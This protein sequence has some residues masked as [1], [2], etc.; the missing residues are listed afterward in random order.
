[1]EA[2]NFGTKTA[3]DRI[4]LDIAGQQRR[5]EARCRREGR[6]IVAKVIEFYIPNNPRK[7]MKWVPRELRGKIIEFASPIEKSAIEKS[8]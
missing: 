6:L 8:A 4:A 5:S 7:S 3:L 1:V 2:R